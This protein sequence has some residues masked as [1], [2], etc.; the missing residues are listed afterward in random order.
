MLFR[1]LNVLALSAWVAAALLVSV[2]A[3]SVKSSRASAE[4]AGIYDRAVSA[5][6][7]GKWGELDT[8][9]R[10][11]GEL[12]ALPA[13]QTADLAYIR[14]S[15]AESCPAWWRQ[16]KEQKMFTFPLIVWERKFTAVFDPGAKSGLQANYSGSQVSL[17]LSWGTADM[18]SPAH[19]EHGFSK[20]ELAAL[21][22]WVTLG[23]AKSWA[24]IPLSTWRGIKDADQPRI[25]RY[26]DFRG[27]VT[28]VY[29]APPRSRHW[30]LFLF[31]LAYLEKYAK[32]PT[33]MSR[34]ALGAM[35]AAEV[36]A[37]PER[38]PSLPLP[39]T[40]PA[41]GAEAKL[42]LHLKDWIEKHGWTLAEDRALREATRA[43]AVANENSTLQS[44]LVKLANGTMVSLDPAAD[45]PYRQKRD[46]WIWA[47]VN[48]MGPGGK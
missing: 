43:L 44:S 7:T 32:M 4:P 8:L 45:T 17:T 2:R 21:G 20:G 6:L 19:A 47:R 25:Q 10:A 26:L 34:R 42:V 14:Q 48:K 38:Y 33:V 30:G 35:F 3:E 36:A 22:I 40:L 37:H 27:N 28:G 18:D 1:P 31:S 9:L 15:V 29:Y 24:E 46:A 13:A 23:M 5:Y 11:P 16:S 12:A 41:D 39:K